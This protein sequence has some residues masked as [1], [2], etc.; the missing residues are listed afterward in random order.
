MSGTPEWLKEKVRAYYQATNESSYLANWSGKALSYHYGL[1]DAS[2][3]SLDEAHINSNIYLADH[4]GIGAGTRVLDAG[5]GVGGTSLWLAKERGAKV[6]GITLDPQQ[7]GLA[8]GF[9]KERGVESSV[10]FAV[11]D[12]MATSFPPRSFD[13]ALNLESLC[14]CADTRAYFT[15]LRGILEPGGVYGCME[16][17]VGTGQPE[18]VREVMEGWA[19]PHWQT[20]PAVIQAL[21]DAGFEDVQATDLTEQV[22][23]SAT[24]MRAMAQNSLLVMKLQ[25]AIDGRDNA[26]YEGHVKGAIAAADG[27]F[28]GGVT[29]GF[30]RAR[31]P[32]R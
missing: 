15:H 3:K 6:Q 22:K 8:N 31:T 12:Y 29:Y 5:C 28:A 23:M 10:T 30:V 25:R 9:A 13:V 1:A 18:I 11:M 14:H 32:A 7:V 27:L 17:F 24:Q 16:F 2:T 4:L 19:M 26:I 21:E 20:M